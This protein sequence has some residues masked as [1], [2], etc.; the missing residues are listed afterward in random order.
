[1]KKSFETKDS[2][3]RQ[4]YES[5]MNRDTQD[6]KPDFSLIMPEEMPYDIQ[7]L[8]RF[9]E[10]MTRGAIKYGERNWEKAN[11]LKELRRFKKSAFRH[12]MQ[13]HCGEEDEDHMAAV[14][15]NLNAA[16]F[17]KFKLLENPDA[18]S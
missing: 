9:A 16:E 4:E 11:S 3:V 12:F 8:T 10:L 7:P 2:G 1:M 6:G 18:K 13:W 17:V 5:G 15:F 14:M